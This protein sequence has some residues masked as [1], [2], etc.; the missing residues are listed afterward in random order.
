MFYQQMPF[1]PRA[2]QPYQPYSPQQQY[3]PTEPPQQV[4]QQTVGY[5]YQSLKA[6]VLQ[7]VMPWVQHGLKEAQHTSVPHAMM[8][9]AAIAYLIGKGLDPQTAHYVVESWEKGESF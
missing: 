5:Q 8:E 6:P 9:V 7:A 1:D 3:V 4:V 2:M